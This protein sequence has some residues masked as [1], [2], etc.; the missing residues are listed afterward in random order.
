MSKTIGLP[1]WSGGTLT[2][3]DGAPS[4]ESSCSVSAGFSLYLAA[5]AFNSACCAADNGSPLTGAVRNDG[6]VNRVFEKITVKT[7]VPGFLSSV[8]SLP[9]PLGKLKSRPW[10]TLL[11]VTPESGDGFVVRNAVG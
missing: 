4:V 11:L 2:R 10:T 9:S 3:T 7:S 1:V 5:K 6:V 8:R